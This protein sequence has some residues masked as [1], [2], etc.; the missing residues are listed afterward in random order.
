MNN[1]TLTVTIPF[2]FKGKEYKP[3]AIIDLD[4]YTRTNQDFNFLFHLVATEN[5]IDRYSYE[6]EVLESSPLIFSQATGKAK[7]F[8]DGNHFDLEGYIAQRK[9]TEAQE[10][11]QNIAS[12]ILKIDKLEEKDPLYEA[13]HK[14]YLAGRESIIND[15]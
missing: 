2:S 3:T 14:A 7:Q 5:N 1:N 13:L 10:I 9:N 11:L 8:L 6:Y 4:T 15:N 12:E